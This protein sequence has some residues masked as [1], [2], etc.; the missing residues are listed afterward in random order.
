M[1]QK[2]DK[3]RRIGK[4]IKKGLKTDEEEYW[5]ERLGDQSDSKK[6]WASVKDLLGERK[7][8]SPTFM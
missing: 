5:K 3:E 4:E 6:M 8:L 2:K 1:R 7:N